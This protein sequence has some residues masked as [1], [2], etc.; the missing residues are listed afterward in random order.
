MIILLVFNLNF[1]IFKVPTLENFVMN[2][3]QGDYMETTMYKIFISI[4]EKTN[5]KEVKT[6]IFK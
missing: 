6:F 3:I 5:L 2:R 1:L 4:D